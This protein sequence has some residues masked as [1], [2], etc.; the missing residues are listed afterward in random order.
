MHVIII[1]L[2]HELKKE[3]HM[4]ALQQAILHERCPQITLKVKRADPN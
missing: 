2:S 4:A 3:V 1:E